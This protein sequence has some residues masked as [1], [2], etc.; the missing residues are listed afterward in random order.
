ML[1]GGFFGGE[2]FGFNVPTRE[3]V[4]VSRAHAA[5]G[6]AVSAVRNAATWFGE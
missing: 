5:F 4:I 3:T 2:S 6:W 1:G